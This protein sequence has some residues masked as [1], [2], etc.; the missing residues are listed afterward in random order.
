MTKQDTLSR[1]FLNTCLILLFFKNVRTYPQVKVDK[2]MQNGNQTI[3]RFNRENQLSI[4]E[5]NFTHGPNTN[6]RARLFQNDNPELL[7][8]ANRHDRIDGKFVFPTDNRPYTD[9]LSSISSR[10]LAPVCHGSTYCER[11]YDYPEE[12]INNAIQQNSSIQFFATTDV[13]PD[14]TK[15]IGVGNT[16]LCASNEKIIYPRSAE[17]KT[18]EWFVIVNQDNFKQGVRIETCGSNENSMCN[19]K[20][21]SLAEGYKSTCKQKFIYRQMAAIS[22]DGKIFPEMFRF[23]SSCCCHVKFTVDPVGRLGIRSKALTSKSLL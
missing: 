21:M 6:S 14:I 8:Q 5:S 19:I 16:P 17:S 9:S 23:P 18:K 1:I 15:R 12:T 3:A 11:V 7:N 10:I 20:G 2:S 4:S 22:K 13:L